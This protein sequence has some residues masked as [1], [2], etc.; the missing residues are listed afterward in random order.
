MAGVNVP[1]WLDFNDA[2]NFNRERMARYLNLEALYE[3]TG[4]VDWMPEKHFPAERI[5]CLIGTNRLDY[6]AAHGL[7]RAFVGHGSDGLVRIE[8]AWLRGADEQSTAARPTA[9]AFVYRSHSG[10]Y[11]IVNSEEAYQNLVRFLFGD[12]R[13]DIYLDIEAIRLPDKVAEAQAGGEDVD[14]LYQVELLA[15]PR[16]KLWYLTR[17]TAEE[18][19]VACLSHRAWRED[20]NRGRNLYL[21]TVFLAKRARV[22]PNRASL[23]YSVT[24]GVRVP[25]YEINRKLWVDQHYEGGYLFRDSVVIE[26]IAP[27]PERPAWTVKYDWQSCSR[28]ANTPLAA[29]A[30]KRGKVELALPFAGG[31]SPGVSGKLRFVA[32]QWR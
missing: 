11:G 12:V 25:D 14:A 21:S 9:K 20:P 31:T 13:V 27:E 30:D 1:G 17:R 26:L 4:R 2:D 23:A 18:D 7:S 10:R 32:S 29:A 8:N 15:A 5:F 3:R 19:S 28:G 6:E 16:G 24:L 22:N